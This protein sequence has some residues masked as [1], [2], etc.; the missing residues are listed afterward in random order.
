MSYYDCILI[1]SDVDNFLNS[2]DE[3]MYYMD[4]MD[5]NIER[6]EQEMFNQA[7]ADS[8]HLYKNYEKKPNIN[9]NLKSNTY[10]QIKK[11]SS[12]LVEQQ[13]K[14]DKNK[15]SIDNNCS[16]CFEL[17]NNNDNVIIL[18]CN[19]VYHNNC[20]NEWV[21]YKSECPICRKEIECINEEKKEIECI[22]EEKKEEK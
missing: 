2:L 5:I 13:L 1:N 7:Q 22:N 16:I 9:I 20:I 17:F 4:Y 3:M 19:H 15:V 10:E 8:L 18:N 6:Y 14:S 21:K 11:I 12:S